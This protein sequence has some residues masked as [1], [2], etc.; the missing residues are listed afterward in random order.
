[1]HLDLKGCT[2]TFAHLCE[3]VVTLARHKINTLLI[4]YED[5]FPYERHPVLRSPEALT[6]DELRAFL[7]LCRDHHLRTIP[8]LQ[9]LGHVEYILRHPEYAHLREEGSAAQFCPR[10][11]GSLM[12]YQELLAEILAYHQDAAYIHIGADE[13]RDLG[14]CPRCREATAA[15]GRTGLYLDHVNAC[16]RLV[17][18]LG[19]TPILWADMIRNACAPELMNRVQPGAIPCDWLYDVSDDEVPFVYWGGGER[20]TSRRWLEL[21]PTRAASRNGLFIEDLPADQLQVMRKYWDRGRF[22]LWNDSLPLVKLLTEKRSPVLGC[23]ATKGGTSSRRL[24]PEWGETFGNIVC[25]GRRAASAGLLGVFGT[26]WARWSSLMNPCEPLEYGWYTMLAAAD[27]FWHPRPADRAEFDRRF[28]QEFLGLPDDTV[29]R[30][31]RA[32][33]N[34]GSAE[35]AIQLLT[36]IQGQGLRPTHLVFLLKAAE[37]AAYQAGARA[38]LDD[39]D[40]RAYQFEGTDGFTIPDAEREV[41]IRR[42]EAF[43]DKRREIAVDLE[44]TLRLTMK[45]TDAREVVLSQL[46]GL[47]RRLRDYLQLLRA[48]ID[49]ATRRSAG[50][51]T[52]KTL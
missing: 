31:M 27:Y 45:P 21:D 28:A 25:W 9:S 18:G 3:L 49:T 7:D 42:V 17:Q 41:L 22:P 13:C 33:E 34:T 40:V 16:L 38:F 37:V 35:A 30:A 43:L 6:P 44:T 46:G 52:G 26:T 1:M 8:L 24:F 12:L 15:K 14:K 10:H 51:T 50:S 39:L 11:P 48:G 20:L 2:P 5:K 4:E 23:C 47:E 19:K 29:P 36:P 32:L